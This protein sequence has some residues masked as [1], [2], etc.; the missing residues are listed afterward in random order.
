MNQFLTAHNRWVRWVGVAAFVVI[1]ALGVFPAR[2]YAAGLVIC[3]SDQNESTLAQNV[4]KSGGSTASLS[5]FNAVS[6]GNSSCQF[7]QLIPE[8]TH[9]INWLIAG[10]GLYAVVWIVLIG[11]RMT[12][13]SSDEHAMKGLKEQLNSVIVGLIVILLAFILVNTLYAAFQI[14]INGASGFNFNPFQ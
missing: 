12:L 6:N 5:A 13:Q 7:S 10:A 1:F 9:L 2:S 4:N 11:F 8:I 3:G 14:K